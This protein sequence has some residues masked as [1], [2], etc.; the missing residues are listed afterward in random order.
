MG[1]NE[2]KLEKF[3]KV[4]KQY[5]DKYK[6]KYNYNKL[7]KIERTKEEEFFKKYKV[8]KEW[9]EWGEVKEEYKK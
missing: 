4:M 3:I 9:E 6:E 1:N 5:S 2:E 8:K 7:Q